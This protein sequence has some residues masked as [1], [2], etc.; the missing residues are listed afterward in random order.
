MDRALGAGP[1]QGHL[2]RG[3]GFV[4]QPRALGGAARHEVPEP[5]LHRHARGQGR[6]D[7]RDQGARRLQSARRPADPVH[8]ARVRPAARGDPVRQ[9]DP[10]QS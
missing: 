10:S 3:D 2:F 5:D 8:G 9:V 1:P 4:H 7:R 6:G